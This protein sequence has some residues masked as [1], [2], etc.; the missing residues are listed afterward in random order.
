MT[1][2]LNIDINNIKN[3]SKPELKKLV[4]K[5]IC[6]RMVNKIQRTRK[7][8]KLRFVK[9][10]NT[11]E[12]KEYVSKM[13]GSEA[14]QVIKTRLNMLPIYGNFKHDLSLRRLCLLCDKE[15][16]TTE[17]LLSCESM[18]VNNISP[19]HLENDDNVQLWHQINEMTSFNL[20][21]RPN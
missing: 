18:G 3:M 15:D 21:N 5:E 6:K 11:F 8:K 1:N 4:K 10:T 14:V 7:T 16:D 2:S 13:S 12:K 20:R 9:T 19:E 17:H